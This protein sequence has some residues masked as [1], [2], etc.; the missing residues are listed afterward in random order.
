M[1][2]SNK[3]EYENVVP[4]DDIGRYNES[5]K[6]TVGACSTTF[7]NLLI[8]L[9]MIRPRENNNH[10]Q[11]GSPLF[12]DSSYHRSQRLL[13]EIITKTFNI[14]TEKLPKE[15]SLQSLRTLQV[16]SS[17]DGNGQKR[18]IRIKEN[19]DTYIGRIIEKHIKQRELL[20]LRDYMMD[21]SDSPL[22]MYD[23]LSARMFDAD[24]SRMQ[25]DNPCPPKVY[26][27]FFMTDVQI[28]ERLLR[29]TENNDDI[30]IVS[31]EPVMDQQNRR[32]IQPNRNSPN[33]MIDDSQAMHKEKDS[34]R[35]PRRADV[36]E[37]LES[38]KFYQRRTSVDEVG[39]GGNEDGNGA[40]SSGS[41]RLLTASTRFR[42][43][44]RNDYNGS[45][46]GYY[47]RIHPL[48]ALFSDGGE[49]IQGQ[50]AESPA[51]YRVVFVYG[52]RFIRSY[53]VPKLVWTPDGF[54]VR[55]MQEESSKRPFVG[56]ETDELSNELK[57]EYGGRTNDSTK[58]NLGGLHK[59]SW[60]QD[61]S[62]SKHNNRSR[63]M[64]V[65]QLT[66]V[67]H[68]CS[69]R[70]FERLLSIVDDLDSCCFFIKLEKIEEAIN[71]LDAEEDN[72]GRVAFY[73]RYFRDSSDDSFNSQAQGTGTTTML[74]SG[75]VHALRWLRSLRDAWVKIYEKYVEIIT[76]N[77]EGVEVWEE[78]ESAIKKAKSF[79][80]RARIPGNE[81]A[82][83]IERQE[84]IED[85]KTKIQILNMQETSPG[86]ST[87]TNPDIQKGIAYYQHC[88]QIVKGDRGLGAEVI[89]RIIGSPEHDGKSRKFAPEGGVK[90]KSSKDGS[91]APTSK[92]LSFDFNPKTP[93]QPVFTFG[94]PL[95]SGASVPFGAPVPPVPEFG[96]PNAAPFAFPS[97][98][99]MTSVAFKGGSGSGK[100]LNRKKKIK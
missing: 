60:F 84:F 64:L 76:S 34:F 15:I 54:K 17:C 29:N 12:N 98:E 24:K 46:T 67:A 45:S 58:L 74:W 94:T 56:Y 14:S 42:L 1:L 52:E 57:Y 70:N 62:S 30:Y 93:I 4:G 89:Q 65:K 37:W 18:F 40:D 38:D 23:A 59:R 13:K 25:D 100:S 88:I 5:S 69:P 96:A 91:S 21:T 72:K 22:A 10:S 33:V 2:S 71:D 78:D 51:K 48:T 3:K 11:D 85:C 27:F 81:R 19:P 63:Q 75:F 61:A 53:T 79:N 43:Q 99:K 55:C 80:M 44:K 16:K 7:I 26:P 95:P 83:D 82:S 31:L 8:N 20:E 77:H 68:Q 39:I 41:S 28:L 90:D 66:E 87:E 49:G 97:S 86:Q 73:K 47:L 32:V 92:P 6:T 36:R 50:I 35:Y 9:A